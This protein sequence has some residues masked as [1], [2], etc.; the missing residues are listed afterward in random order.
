[1]EQNAR[2]KT[3][4]GAFFGLSGFDVVYE[5][6]CLPERDHKVKA[7]RH[8]LVL[9]G[10]ALNAARTFARLGGEALLVTAIGD[11]PLGEAMKAMIRAEGIRVFDLT[12][13]QKEV[14]VSTV[15]LRGNTR[16]LISGQAPLPDCFVPPNLPRFDFALYDLNL[17]KWTRPL[18]ETIMGPH[19]VLD[20]GSPKE[21]DGFALSHAECI[22]MSEH[23]DKQPL[24]SFCARRCS[25]SALIARTRGAKNIQWCAHEKK[26]GNRCHAHRG[27]QYPWG[28]RR[29]PWRVL[30]LLLWRASS[31]WKIPAKSQRN[32][33]NAH[34]R[35]LV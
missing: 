17:P 35:N 12:P 26:R 28:G 14:N 6:T 8:R 29:V 27:R 16:T 24:S 5:D 13:D 34:P 2:V 9:G 33:R 30:L 18:V 23:F 21:N 32:R 20:A 3:C 4:I 31:V 10:T 15:F 11:S 25:P 1:M 19:L 7:T 22:I